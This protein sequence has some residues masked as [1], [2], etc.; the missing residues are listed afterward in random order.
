MAPESRRAIYRDTAKTL[1][2]LH[3]AN[4]DSV[5]LGNYGRRNDYCKRQIE[6]WAKQYV[7]STNEGNPASNP[8]MFA[9]IDWLRHHIPSEDSSG[10]TAGL[11]HGDF[12]IDN[13]VFHPTE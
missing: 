2:S 12:R 4:V 3:S 7:S 10:A 6:R 9:L 8:K 11:V 1:A 13:L 5:G